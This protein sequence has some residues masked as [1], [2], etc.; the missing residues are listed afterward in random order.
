[1]RVVPGGPQDSVKRAPLAALLLL[2]GLFLS[3]AGAAPGGEVRLAAGS[4]SDLHR[5][6]VVRVPGQT[7]SDDEGAE[8][9]PLSFVP[10]RPPVILTE[11]GP[12]RPLSKA[13]AAGCAARPSIPCTP[14]RARAPPAA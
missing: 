5:A 3:P 9:N 4:L 7:E 6:A 10:E 11:T 12:A 13:M 14:Y 1:M 8:P 2:F